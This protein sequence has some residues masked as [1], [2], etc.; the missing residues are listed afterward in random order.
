MISSLHFCSI[1]ICSS[2][3][4][5][6]LLPSTTLIIFGFFLRILMSF[7]YPLSLFL[8]LCSSLSPL[9]SVS[10]AAPSLC[11]CPSFSLPLSLLLS[12][13]I[14]LF[15]PNFIFLFLF[16]ILLFFPQVSGSEDGSLRVWDIWTKQCLKEVKPLNKTAVTNA[17][18][19]E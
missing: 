6:I 9:F 15:V 5:S 10:F 17:I 7:A 2:L 18:V 16:S 8:F 11:L 3:L 4:W 1:Q 19:R 12:V 14:S 13:C